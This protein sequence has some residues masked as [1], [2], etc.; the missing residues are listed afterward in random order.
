SNLSFC[1][2]PKAK[3]QHPSSQQQPSPTVCGGIVLKDPCPSAR[4]VSVQLKEPF[5]GEGGVLAVGHGEDTIK[6]IF[7]KR[8]EKCKS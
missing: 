3:T 1:A 6:G 5:M 8:L 4:E 7:P 2:E